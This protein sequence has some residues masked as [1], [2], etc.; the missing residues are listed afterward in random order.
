MSVVNPIAIPPTSNDGETAS[1]SLPPEPA[2]PTKVGGGGNTILSDKVSRALSVRTDTPAMRAAL[3]ALSNLSTTQQNLKDG[4]LSS[5]KDV[6]VHFG[7]GAGIDARSVRVAI[8]QDALY[9]A[10]LLQSELKKLVDTVHS[11]HESIL[12]VSDI[13]TT[14]TQSINGNVLVHSTNEVIDSPSSEFQ[15][16]QQ[17]NISESKN[18][19]TVS[20]TKDSAGDNSDGSYQ[21][22]YNLAAM[23]A[24]AFHE[25]DEARK[26]N[27]EIT[28]FLDKFNVSD[29][30]NY[31]LEHYNFEDIFG[32]NNDLDQY[33]RRN[34]L[35][36]DMEQDNGMKDGMAFLD[37]LLRVSK[38]RRELSQSFGDQTEDNFSS[39]ID[40]E[41][42]SPFQNDLITRSKSSRLGAT[43]AVR[44]IEHLATKQEK[45]F[46]RLYHFLHSHLDLSNTLSANVPTSS[47]STTNVQALRKD[48]DK[49]DET[50]GH[51]F[52]R[53]ALL[54]LRHVPA[55][56]THTLEL[57]ATSRRSE[58]TRKF[59]LALTSG[60][61]GMA[62]IEMKAHDPINY[63]GDMLAFVFRALNVESLLAKGLMAQDNSEFKDLEATDDN[64]DILEDLQADDELVTTPKSAIDVLNDAMSGVGRPLRSRLNQVI[65]SLARRSDDEEN[66]EI[67]IRINEY[68]GSNFMDEEVSGARLRLSSL[69]SIC[70]LLLFYH[71]AMRKAVSKIDSTSAKGK[72]ITGEDDTDSSSMGPLVQCL[73]ESLEEASKAYIASLRVYSA[74][75]DQFATASNERPAAL[76]NAVIIRLCDVRSASPGFG[77]DVSVTS[78]V[79]SKA[80]SLDYLCE[81]VIESAIPS[82]NKLDDTVTLKDALNEAKKVGL[83][84]TCFSNWQ[85]IV[86]DKEKGLVDELIDSD[87][88]YVMEECGLATIHKAIESMKAVFI[89]GMTVSSHPGLS[90]EEVRD[91]FE[92]F[93]TSL[94]APPIPSYENIKDPVLRKMARAKI[95]LNLS[96]VYKEICETILSDKGGY[97]DTSFIVHK[98]EQVESLLSS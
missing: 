36:D 47:S 3:D 52:V 64:D 46:E 5:K 8:E 75:L 19:E 71:S 77:P 66:D 82:C 88:S 14:V 6:D 18:D 24:D 37:A 59:L 53:R 73:L 65:S 86:D 43:S 20:E 39:S 56:Y 38:I 54:A 67:A 11:M 79:A 96:H 97:S 22:E 83:D 1:S 81:T 32:P 40:G 98:P 60:Y 41:L 16:Q 69:Y 48:D 50:L 95:A 70:G 9:Q 91:A 72:D 26:R 63:V 94:H 58:V 85:K 25:R 55:Y 42:E 28:T 15:Q 80:L 90:L 68:Q 51:P 89:E 4:H 27:E 62:P 34:S 21:Q 35:G 17:D 93:Y 87:T 13:A 2:S 61:G 92:T 44:M 84:R 33:Q 57:I 45:A 31:L 23:L 78:E 49:L 12:E 76:A 29:S 74:M 7:M 30:D 10:R